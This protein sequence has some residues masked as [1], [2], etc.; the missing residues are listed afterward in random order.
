MNQGLCHVT[1]EAGF[2]RLA[3]VALATGTSFEQCVAVHVFRPLGMLG[4]TLRNV[5]GDRQR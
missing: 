3:A 4:M 1:I 5:A 2:A